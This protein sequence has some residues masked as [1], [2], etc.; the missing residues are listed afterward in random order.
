MKEIIL[1]EE[2]NTKSISLEE[3]PTNYSSLSVSELRKIVS[4]KK[5]VS[6]SKN[7]KK[8]ELLDILNNQ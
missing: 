1:N 7:L 2:D 5:L 4:S 6:S 8:Q 3:T